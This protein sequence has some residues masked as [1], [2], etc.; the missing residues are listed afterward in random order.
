MNRS[1]Y[2]DCYH[3]EWEII[4]WRGAVKSALRGR[5]G[6]DFLQALLDALDAMEPKALIHGELEEDGE[7][8]ALG[9]VLRVREIDMT[10]LDPEDH[11]RIGLLL[12]IA[13]ALVAEVSFINDDAV[14]WRKPHRTPA[15][16]W[17]AVR[18]WAVTQLQDDGSRPPF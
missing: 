14:I 18:S 7:V 8:C 6:R 10:N 15:E 1:G 3:D 11:E 5:R 13:P 2:N 17:K 12:N 16:R 9:A 4:R